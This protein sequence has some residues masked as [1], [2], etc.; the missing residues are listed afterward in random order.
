MRLTSRRR[1]HYDALLVSNGSISRLKF[2]GVLLCF[3]LSGAAGLVYQ[4]AWSKALGQVFGH[5]VY[6][7]ATV[8]AVFMGGLALGSALLGRWGERFSNSIALYGWI[9]LII[10]AAGAL[11]LAGLALVRQIY[12]QTYDLVSGSLVTLL[13]L[14]FAG[15]AIVLLLP[16][17][18]MG[19]TL[20]ILVHGLTRSSAELGRRVSRLYWVNTLG[21]VAG[22]FAAGFFLL[23]ELGL[24]QTAG[25]AVALNI[26]AGAIALLMA[27]GQAAPQAAA[28]EAAPAPA[29]KLELRTPAFLLAGFALVG[30][31]AM[32][33]EICWS[34]LLSTTLG[35]STYAFTLM[36][37]TFLAGIVLGSLLFDLW[38][39]PQRQITTR[40][41][42]LT[43]TLTAAA[44]LAFLVFFQ[45][46]PEIVPP[47]L[48]ATNKSFTGLILAQFVTS[49]LAMLPAAVIFGF[50]FP[51][52]T[53]LI[54]GRPESGGHHG[55]AV[56]RA[57]AANTLGAILGA[58]LAGFFLV[59]LVGAFRLVALAAIAN[60]LLAV[61]LLVREAPRAWL[62]AAA[63]A[64]LI[65]GVAVAAFSGAFYNRALAVYGTVLY[66]DW[67][68]GKLTLAE[69]AATTDLLF[70]EDG[71]NATISAV[72][73]EDYVAIRSNGKVD[74]SNRDRITQLLAGHLGL[75]FHP[76]PKRVLIIGFG[77]GMTVSAVARHPD[78][79]RIDCVEIEPAVIRAAPHLESLNRNVL[80]DP[81]VHITLDDARNFLLTTRN[82]YDVIISEPS[83]PWI[84]GV[85]S[86]FTDEFY[87][88]AKARLNPG[89]IFVQWVQAYS[90]YPDDF[91][92]VL[93]TF[94]PHFPQ[95]TM[96]RGEPPDYLLLAQA[97]PAPLTLERLRGQWENPALR[98]DFDELQIKRPEALLAYHRLDDG[99]LRLLA[100]GAKHRNTDDR[101]L[102][103]YRA[104]RALLANGLEDQNRR[105]IW[106]H[107]VQ[108]G[109]QNLQVGDLNAAL[110]AA[111]ETM[112]NLNDDDAAHFIRM[113]E[114]APESAELLLV[115][116]RW[117]LRNSIFSEARKNLQR[118]LQLDPGRV[119]IAYYLGE[120]ARRSA[121]LNTA[122]LMYRQVLAR[123]PQFWRAMRGMMYVERSRTRW[124]A[125]AD[126]QARALKAMPDP[127]ADEFARL[128]EVLMRANQN[129]LAERAF[130]QALEREPYSYT[131]HRNL[132][133][134]YH[135]RRDWPRA[136]QHLE[137]VVRY[138]PTSDAGTY[139]TLADV[140]RS[141]NLRRESVAILQKGARI[142]PNEQEILRLLP[143]SN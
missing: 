35:S 46:L 26:L 5:T 47:I 110:T 123:D 98:G 126:W 137:F 72:R 16:T 127:K 97:A 80:A 131:A 66:F 2:L 33:Y 7:I 41:F 30:A 92:M 103:E 17:F 117:H 54:A 42:A 83:N 136:R 125:A 138:H 59:P 91:R 82:H 25:V 122:E 14:R 108:P 15:A 99:A 69:Q 140:Y 65:L 31:T 55:A 67:Y 116:G 135:S 62:T 129:D 93:G 100:S 58:V 4:V 61:Y 22:T 101:T 52:V 44:A 43:Q 12:F 84:A 37:G 74:A 50:N 120:T 40:T 49:A 48:T 28:A 121:D 63:N 75:L 94:V 19:G 39:S 96:W 102:L 109:S 105:V 143:P 32:A 119:E 95:V 118:A 23:P 87:R 130:R 53:V 85:S 27:R 124:D 134:L 29:A 34:R 21:A 132:G 90:L 68:E 76:T 11:S 6:A 142:F 104:P 57:Y 106:D 114:G 86:L 139:T 18:L 77:S 10:A 70:A 133:A 60:L 1:A 51:V 113:L 81:R 112:V 111:A 8:L 107:R 115:R 36:L 89:G 24:R 141:L 128:G 56:G 73:T 45:Q 88:E 13:A 79:E 64:L 20:P 3:F 9:E 71:L 38:A 78:V